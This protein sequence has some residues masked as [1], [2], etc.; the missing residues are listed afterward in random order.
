MKEIWRGFAVLVFMMI[1]TGVLYPLL[2][3]GI[4]EVAF[5]Q[6]VNGSLINQDGTLMGS[7][8]IGQNFTSPRYFWGRPSATSPVPYNASVSGAS[9][10]GPMN[11]ALIDQIKARIAAFTSADP[12]QKDPIPVD[13]V[14][15][16]G[17]GLD[18][19]ISVASANY[20]APRVAKARG[21]TLDQV[22]VLI[23]EN[24][25]L[26]QF[27]FMGQARVNVLK[28]NMA[29]DQLQAAKHS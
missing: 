3:T 27:G 14:T 4:G 22:N 8:L 19:D 16:S 11:P 17:S 28:L 20:Q 21:L 9:N 24:T 12:T 25:T 18:P 1:L 6:Q 7:S 26:P 15:S 2:M 29:L 13:L 10:L 5:S 23:L